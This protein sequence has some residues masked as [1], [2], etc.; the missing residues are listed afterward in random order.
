VSSTTASLSLTAGGTDF[1][2]DAASRLTYSTSKTA[3]N[4]LTV[5]YANAFRRSH[6]APP[7]VLFGPGVG[8]NDAVKT[9]PVRADVDHAPYVALT[10]FRRGGAPVTTP[11]GFVGRVHTPALIERGATR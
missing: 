8:E 11:V 5:Q 4:T 6:P 9:R 3:L 7:V 2:G 10:T 1:G